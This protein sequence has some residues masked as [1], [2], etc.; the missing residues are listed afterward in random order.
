MNAE[1]TIGT[2]VTGPHTVVVEPGHPRWAEFLASSPA[3]YAPSPPTAEDYRAAVQAHIDAVA[4]ARLYDSGQSLASYA[5][6]TNAAWAAEAAAFIAWRDVVWAQVYALWA[7]PP[8][9]PP[10]VATLIAGL[11]AITWP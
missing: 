8:D 11:P 3:T 1:Q 5:A 9:P 2:I 6:S 10:T 4:Q 7:D